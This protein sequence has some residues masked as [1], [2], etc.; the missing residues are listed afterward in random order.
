MGNTITGFINGIP[1]IGCLYECLFKSVD[2]KLKL[3]L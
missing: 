3:D 1:Y 2:W